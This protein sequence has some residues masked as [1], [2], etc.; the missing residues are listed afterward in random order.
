MRPSVPSGHS[1]SLTSRPQLTFGEGW[2]GKSPRQPGRAEQGVR[3]PVPPHPPAHRA[4]ATGA[5]RHSVRPPRHPEPSPSRPVGP[6]SPTLTLSQH[7]HVAESVTPWAS[8]PERRWIP[9]GDLAEKLEPRASQA[10]QIAA[11]RARA[12]D[13]SEAR[14]AP[15]PRG[16]E[17]AGRGK[18]GT[19]FGWM[20]GRL[21]VS[22]VCSNSSVPCVYEISIR[23]IH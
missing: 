18:P 10:R 4:P 16:G 5:H 8:G 23:I 17:W 15:G 22:K 12:A 20:L 9:L 14:L 21:A 7:R 1:Q 13:V 11:A 19:A 3:D 2:A 6:P